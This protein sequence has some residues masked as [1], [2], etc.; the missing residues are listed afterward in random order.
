MLSTVYSRF[1]IE[2]RHW[3]DGESVKKPMHVLGI[4]LYKMG[5]IIYKIDEIIK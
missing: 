3:S 5:N 1:F 4:W 2:R